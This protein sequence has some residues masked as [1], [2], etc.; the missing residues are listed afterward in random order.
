MTQV[1]Q[2]PLELH[3]Q[4]RE[5]YAEGFGYVAIGKKLGVSSTTIRRWLFPEVHQHSLCKARAYKASRAKQCANCGVTIWYTST[6]CADCSQEKQRQERLW[7]RER[8]ILAIQNWAR[9]YGSPPAATQWRRSG[10]AHPSIG[11]VYG[12][13]GV[14]SSWNEAI[15]AAGF[16]PRHSNPGP[17]KS[18]W[19]N[20]EARKLRAEGL[21]N[22]EIGERFGVTPTAISHRIGIEGSRQPRSV[23]KKRTREQRIADLRAAIKKG[24]QDGNRNRAGDNHD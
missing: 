13:T 11:A 9:M 14:F 2:H 6:L 16:T 23:I 20:D 12:K 18:S 4:A 8:V 1:L 17:G 19:T 15:A 24:E 7:T 22:R 3:E 5:L 21:S 10:K